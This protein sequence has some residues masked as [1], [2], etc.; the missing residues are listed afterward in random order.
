MAAGLGITLIAFALL[1]MVLGATCIYVL[2][3]MF[4]GKSAEEDKLNW[5]G[6][7]GI[8]SKGEGGQLP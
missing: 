6:E 7:T 4:K 8:I 1:Y 5:Y 2:L 3:R